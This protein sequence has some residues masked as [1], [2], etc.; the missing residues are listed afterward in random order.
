MGVRVLLI[1]DEFPDIDLMTEGIPRPRHASVTPD[2]L[3]R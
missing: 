3:I 1:P 2:N